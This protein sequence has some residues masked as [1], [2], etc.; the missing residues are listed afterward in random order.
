[1]PT[2]DLTKENQETVS[3]AIKNYNQELL[4]IESKKQLQEQI[5]PLQK[6]SIIKSKKRNSEIQVYFETI[7][8][9]RS[10][11]I[12]ENIPQNIL[13]NIL[14]YIFDKITYNLIDYCITPQ[15][16]S[17][18]IAKNIAKNIIE[19]ISEK[20][21]ENIAKNI[22]ENVSKK[23]PD[24]IFDDIS[25][26][27]KYLEKIK[28][29][30]GIDDDY[31]D[32]LENF[33]ALTE[34]KN[35]TDKFFQSV[36]RL[37][38]IELANLAQD[39]NFINL[40]SQQSKTHKDA[41]TSLVELIITNYSK[42]D[43]LS[44]IFDKNSLQEK[45]GPDYA[46]NSSIPKWFQLLSFWFSKLIGKIE[47]EVSDQANYD[48]LSKAIDIIQTPKGAIINDKRSKAID[49]V[50]QQIKSVNNSASIMD[51]S[52]SA[53]NQQRTNRTSSVVGNSCNLFK[54]QPTK[55]STEGLGASP[56]FI[57]IQR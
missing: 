43:L 29:T 36:G 16:I 53:N 4:E 34:I 35:C 17:E 5:K 30:M 48:K 2:K 13:N 19:N 52:V 51:N 55:K 50:M 14:Y 32:K 31:L 33:D 10:K 7:L 27:L 11:N 20:I 3:N 54:D 56:F 28:K 25:K 9:K 49:F 57:H 12:V 44:Q 45:T 22:I 46:N 6:L 42:K 18:N 24:N 23:I 1:M 38:P 41:A 39:Q 40:T 26:H 15:N 21:P 37:K 47:Y 8:R